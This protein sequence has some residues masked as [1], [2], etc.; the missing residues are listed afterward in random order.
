ME[1]RFRRAIFL[2][3]S[4]CLWAVCVGYTG[5]FFLWEV[6]GNSRQFEE[7]R[8]QEL[9]HQLRLSQDLLEKEKGR[10]LVEALRHGLRTGD[11]DFFGWKQ[12]GKWVS[13]EGH[14]AAEPFSTLEGQVSR[15]GDAMVTK[16]TFGAKEL[17]LGSF[18]GWRARAD[19]VVSQRLAY[20]AKDILFFA[21]ALIM[22]SIF[23]FQELA[24]AFMPKPVVQRDWQSPRPKFEPKILREK[25]RTQKHS[26]TFASL[27]IPSSFE[28]NTEEKAKELD[29]ALFV[30]TDLAERYGGVM[31]EHGCTGG[32]FLFEEANL[33]LAAAR[34][35]KSLNDASVFVTQGSTYP[36]ASGR[37]HY[38][39]DLARGIKRLSAL[40]LEPGIWLSH[41]IEAG[42]FRQEPRSGLFQAVPVLTL[43]AALDHAREGE[44]SGLVFFRRDEDIIAVLEDLQSGNWKREFFLRALCSLRSFQCSTE[45]KTL[46]TA[47]MNLLRKELKE[48]DSYR[49]SSVLALA[50]HLFHPKAISRELEKTFLEVLALPDRRTKANSIEVFIHFFPEREIPALRPYLKDIDNRISANALVKAALE[51][52]DDQVVRKIEERLNGGSVAHVASALYA[53][54]EIALYYQRTDPLYLGTKL[55]FLKIFDMVPVWASHPNPMVGRQ[56]L[57]AAKKLGD[58]SLNRKLEK[59]FQANKD[60]SLEE[61]FGTVYGWRK[62]EKV[63]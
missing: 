58:P 8:T 22:M 39:A 43:K 57:I 16:V 29:H 30:A 50:A 19:E 47:Y 45:S 11:I 21:L 63:A 48:K 35:W 14:E 12:E 42:H 15:S 4:F 61:L 32:S 20:L 10:E 18:V 1:F 56:A 60:A 34:D 52:F 25:N 24:R 49:L 62:Q 37:P 33:A 23:F 13:F 38:G 46:A 40:D 54:G 17:V 59:V 51:R 27:Q 28:V 36:A 41:K 44:A 3:F 53:V 55:S 31:V 5:G 9:R 6:F 26:G 2:K 7:R